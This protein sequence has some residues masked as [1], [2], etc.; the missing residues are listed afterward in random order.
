MFKLEFSTS[1]AGMQT[2]DGDADSYAVADIL[3]QVSSMVS[4]GFTSGPVYD[5]NGNSIGSWSLD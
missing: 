1:N 2:E 4:G 3:N 5:V